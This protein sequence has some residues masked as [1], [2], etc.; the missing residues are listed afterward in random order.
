MAIKIYRAGELP[1]RE[2]LRVLIYGPPRVGKSSLAK[3]ASNPL[4]LDFGPETDAVG[5]S[6]SVLSIRQWSD[7][8]VGIVKE[9]SVEFDSVIVDSLE[10]A[11]RMLIHK[12]TSDDPRLLDAGRL[13]RDGYGALLWGFTRWIE[14][15]KGIEKDIILVAKSRTIERRLPSGRF[16]ERHEIDLL[17]SSRD[18]VPTYTDLIGRIYFNEHKHRM[19]SFGPSAN[20]LSKNPREALKTEAL[21]AIDQ[22]DGHLASLIQQSKDAINAPRG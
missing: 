20:A 13:N 8:D 16:R 6:E 21:P 19:L 2:H 18:E 9:K 14:D 10:L 3:T 4:L 11:Q 7:A 5:A 15:I 1:V 22:M 17:G 12:L